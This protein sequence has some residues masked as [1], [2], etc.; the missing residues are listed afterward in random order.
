MAGKPRKVM[1]DFGGANR[2]IGVAEHNEIAL[3]VERQF[4]PLRGV[5]RVE[6]Q[7]HSRQF[8]ARRNESGNFG[9]VLRIDAD[10]RPEGAVVTNRSIP[11][12]AVPRRA[13]GHP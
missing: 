7:S 10:K 2:G 3:P 1:F 6:H 4:E 11:M 9:G 13:S 5:Y 12:I 8:S